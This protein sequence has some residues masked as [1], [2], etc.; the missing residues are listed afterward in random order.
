MKSEAI[1]RGLRY[2]SEFSV[3]DDD[4]HIEMTTVKE[5]QKGDDEVLDQAG[6]GSDE[7]EF[8]NT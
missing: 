2:D 5:T 4:E 1:K 3:D 6:T 8:E 7:N